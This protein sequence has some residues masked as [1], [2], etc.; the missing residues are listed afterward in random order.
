M[1]AA[2]EKTLTSPI[3]LKAADQ[4]VVT[5]NARAS[6]P[7]R[8]HPK[9]TARGND[10]IDREGLP[11]DTPVLQ[12][13]RN[14]DEAVTEDAAIGIGIGLRPLAQSLRSGRETNP[15]LLSTLSGH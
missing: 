14:T 7:K 6:L 9:C 4:K 15:Q 13:T 10:G 2:C 11:P 5:F 12:N 1:I 3:A 8:R